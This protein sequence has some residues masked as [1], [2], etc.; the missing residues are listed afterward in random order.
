MDRNAD[1][2]LDKGDM[3]P[4][5]DAKG[6]FLRADSDK[7]GKVS[8]AEFKAA[9]PKSPEDRFTKLDKNKDGFLDSVDRELTAPAIPAPAV[10]APRDWPDVIKNFVAQSDANNDGKLSFEEFSKDKPG[11]ARETFDSM[12]TNKDGVISSDDK[13]PTPPT[14]KPKPTRIVQ[15]DGKARFERADKNGDGKLTYD[16]AKTE[17]TNLTEESFKL[18][19]ADGDGF[20]GPNDRAA[21]PKPKPAA[22]ATE[23][24]AEKPAEEKK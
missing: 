13:Q 1:G 12:D 18:R 9:F 20:L 8:A 6:G 11:V 16:E 24:P 15:G 23:A 10:S 22:P 19:D 3:P 14:R 2:V 17:F 7:D 21:R 5:A 4:K